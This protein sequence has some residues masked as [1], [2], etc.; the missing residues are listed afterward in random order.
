MTDRPSLTALLVA[1]VRALYTELPAPYCVAP[2]PFAR[3][4]LP[5]WLAL[6]ARAAG[7][8]PGAAPAV[9]RI[10]G[11]A[12]FGMAHNVALRTRAIDDALREG[13]AGGAT[14]VVVLGAGLD[15]RALRMS[16]LGSVRVLEVDH[17][18][19]HRYKAAR[20]ARAGLAGR[21]RAITVAMDFERERLCD[22][23]P[24]AGLDPRERS[25]WIWEGVTAYLTPSAIT[26][27]LR[28]VGALSALGSRLAMTYTRPGARRG[29]VEPLLVHLGGVVGEP[30]RGMLEREAVHAMLG[31]AG[32][33]CVSEQSAAD[34]APRCWPQAYVTEWER[35]L[36]AER[37]APG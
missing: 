17:P 22:V 11:A 34:W 9:H 26:A 25:F 32:L 15:S 13:L 29:R 12:A 1:A 36:V 21:S 27:T 7:L 35:L 2:D 14:Q 16:E 5:A 3:G 10:V 6:P 18:S 37:R 4:L 8:F 33:A 24:A 20:L 28:A 31:A 23:L 19:T 30:V